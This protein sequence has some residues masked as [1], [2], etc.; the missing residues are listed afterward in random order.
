MFVRFEPKDFISEQKKDTFATGVQISPHPACISLVLITFITLTDLWVNISILPFPLRILS[1][2]LY[3]LRIILLPWFLCAAFS[4]LT[5]KIRIS[6]QSIL[7][8]NLPP[9]QLNMITIRLEDIEKVSV[10]SGIFGKSF[11]YGAL[12]LHLKN[13]KYTLSY[14]KNPGKVKEYLEKLISHH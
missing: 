7:I 1:Y 3:A 8:M 2:T 11:G 5:G 4:F 13:Q 10:R 12:V 6:S 14:V 9:K